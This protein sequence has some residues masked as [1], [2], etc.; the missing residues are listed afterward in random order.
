MLLCK[1]FTFL[2]NYFVSAIKEKWFQINISFPSC[3]GAHLKKRLKI[4]S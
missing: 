1:C 3:R 2:F 4:S